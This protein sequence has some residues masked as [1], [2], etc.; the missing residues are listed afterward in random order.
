MIKRR[1]FGWRRLCIMPAR[2]RI[3][4][5][6]ENLLREWLCRRL[7]GGRIMSVSAGRGGARPS[8]HWRRSLEDQGR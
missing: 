5:N 7:Y 4:M 3:V 2:E 1:R 8:C 6:L